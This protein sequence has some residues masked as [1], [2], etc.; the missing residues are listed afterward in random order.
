MNYK[1]DK[2]T[3]FLEVFMEDC[4]YYEDETDEAGV[5]IYRRESDGKVVG[6]GINNIKQIM[7]EDR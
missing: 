7:E 1:Y 4:D 3:D 6:F 2:T 5:Y